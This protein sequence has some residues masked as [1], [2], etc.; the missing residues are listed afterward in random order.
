VQALIKLGSGDA[1]RTELNKNLEAK[2]MKVSTSV[3]DPVDV[4]NEPQIS[5]PVPRLA[6]KCDTKKW[7]SASGLLRAMAA[8]RT[9]VA[10]GRDRTPRTAAQWAARSQAVQESWTGLGIRHEMQSRFCLRPSSDSVSRTEAVLRKLAGLEVPAPSSRPI[11][12]AHADGY[13]LAKFGDQDRRG[14]MDNFFFR[15]AEVAQGRFE[16]PNLH[17]NHRYKS[18]LEVVVSHDKSEFITELEDLPDL[19][20]IVPNLDVLMTPYPAGDEASE[21]GQCEVSTQRNITLFE[22]Q[23]CAIRGLGVLHLICCVSPGFLL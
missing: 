6:L 17:Q 7:G 23:S 4:D 15:L 12:E 10:D 2:K 8:D 14:A 13:R 9:P 1:L 22:R 20:E 18:A 5:W 3:S 19:N 21:D 11:V 16:H